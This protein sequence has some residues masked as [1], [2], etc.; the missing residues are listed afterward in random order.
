MNLNINEYKNY[1]NPTD[2]EKKDLTFSGEITFR[3]VD[4]ECPEVRKE[5]LFSLDTKLEDDFIY[6]FSGGEISSKDFGFNKFH[7]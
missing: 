2:S 3:E 7:I 1:R 4:L 5:Y 6:V